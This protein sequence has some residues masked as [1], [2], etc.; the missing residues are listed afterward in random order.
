M[1][2][3]AA[4]AALALLPGPAPRSA[5]Q[6]K[7][8][9]PVKAFNHFTLAVWTSSARSISIRVFGM[10]IQARQGQTMVPR[11]GAGRSSLGSARL[12]ESVEHH[13]SSDR[14]RAFNVYRVSRVLAQ[15]GVTQVDTA[16]AR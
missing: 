5:A 12:F 4:Y 6:A 9:I 14:R 13:P 8:Q 10:P 15:Y 11:I 3:R 2:F 7:P 16:A 1:R